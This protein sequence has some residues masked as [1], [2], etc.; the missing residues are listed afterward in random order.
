MQGYIHERLW[1]PAAVDAPTGPYE[2]ALTT[3]RHEGDKKG[4]AVARCTWKT[5]RRF[6]SKSWLVKYEN[7]KT[8]E[9]EILPS[10][11]S[12]AL[13]ERALRWGGKGS[14]SRAFLSGMI[15]FRELYVWRGI[16]VLRVAPRILIFTRRE[17]CASVM[18]LYC[19]TQHPAPS[20]WS[21]SK[22]RDCNLVTRF[23]YILKKKNCAAKGNGSSFSSLKFD[24]N[25][26]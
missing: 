21:S 8:T 20:V 19:I 26:M 14:N 15:G 5:F 12:D 4:V 3:R 23:I 17:L 1:S 10:L 13:E 24:S 25:L 16:F 11:F 2:Y 7:R 22:E 6:D 18:L 9:E